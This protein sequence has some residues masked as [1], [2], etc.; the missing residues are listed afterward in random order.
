MTYVV[1]AYE[2]CEPQVERSR[3]LATGLSAGLSAD[4]RL[5]DPVYVSNQGCNIQTAS[6]A[7]RLFTL[8]A[9]SVYCTEISVYQDGAVGQGRSAQLSA[10]EMEV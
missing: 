7:E 9:P 8:G 5:L 1:R 2:A 6:A 4:A 3:R 10:V